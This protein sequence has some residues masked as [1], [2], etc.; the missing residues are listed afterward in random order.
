MRSDECVGC[1]GT[2]YPRHDRGEQIHVEW[3][4]AAAAVVAAGKKIEARKF[5]YG[6]FAHEPF[7]CG[8]VGNGVQ[9]RDV[10]IG[11][12]VPEDQLAAGC[13]KGREVGV[14]GVVECVQLCGR[15]K[16]GAIEFQVGQCVGR[17]WVCFVGKVLEGSGGDSLTH[18]AVLARAGNVNAG[19]GKL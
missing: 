11:Q 5:V 1:I 8:V 18:H 3:P 12:A 4:F 17:G 13:G 19:P 15:R 6:R 10:R 14:G 7:H 2:L 16:R 9:R